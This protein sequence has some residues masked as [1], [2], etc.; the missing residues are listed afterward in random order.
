MVPT[1]MAA[2]GV[3]EKLLNGYS[4]AGQRFKVHLDGYNMMPFWKGEVAQSP[5]HEFFYWNDEGSLVGLRYDRWKIVFMEQRS[6]GFDVWQDPMVTLRMPKL[7]DLRA[8]RG[9]RH[10]PSLWGCSAVVLRDFSRCSK[11]RSRFRPYPSRG[12][13]PVSGAG[14][15]LAIRRIRRPIQKRGYSDHGA[16]WGRPRGGPFG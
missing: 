14:I 1:L 6:H 13:G 12:H 16:F 5:R 3:K 15:F 4:A 9:F 2:V 10:R 7:I 11:A 8:E